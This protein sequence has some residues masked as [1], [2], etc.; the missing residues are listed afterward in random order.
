MVKSSRTVYLLSYPRTKTCWAPHYGRFLQS[1][2]FRE[3]ARSLDQKL[4]IARSV[5]DGIPFDLNH[6]KAVAAQ[7]YPDGLPEPHSPDPTQWLF[8]G[9][10][11]ESISSL[12]VAV[13]RLMG[14]Q[15]PQEGVDR[16]SC[17]ALPD[18]ILSLASVAGQEPASGRLRRVLSEA[19]GKNWS[20]DLQARLLREVGFAD[21]G[22]D[23][24]LRDG[25]F[26]QHCKLF[27]VNA[28][29]SGTSGMVTGEGFS[30]TSEL[31]ISWIRLT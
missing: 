25:F 26:K 15:W 23:A 1:D 17:F 12:Q 8:G 2:R 30:C 27:R 7:Q 5:F 19:Y 6:W 21:K 31:S 4:A 14:Y 9:N 13:T 20:A 10:P 29:L 28:L 24:W 18:G 22:I 3:V 16:L 11:V